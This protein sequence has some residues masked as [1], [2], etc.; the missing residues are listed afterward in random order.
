LIELSQKL[1]K[2]E[3]EVNSHKQEINSHKQEIKS[4]RVSLKIQK[5]SA[6]SYTTLGMAVQHQLRLSS[7]CSTE[8]FVSKYLQPVDLPIKTLWNTW[9]VEHQNEV[10][11]AFAK[12]AGNK[13]K[14]KEKN[15]EESKGENKELKFIQPVVNN[16]FK[17]LAPSNLRIW[18]NKSLHRID[19]KKPDIAVTYKT[20]GR[21]SSQNT[22]LQGEVKIDFHTQKIK[23]LGQLRDYV[24]RMIGG[25]D[26]RTV[27]FGVA[28]SL[29]TIPP[30]VGLYQR[31]S[32][33]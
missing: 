23:I 27:G 6:T 25:Q 7:Q 30:T 22:I 15:K 2:L 16:L 32:N 12:I 31:R 17:H 33:C 19:Q 5:T 10:D 21:L 4:L 29:S 26:N 1:S 3:L 14:N 20:E 24:A 18:S 9:V 13:E 28:L 8:Q 11:N